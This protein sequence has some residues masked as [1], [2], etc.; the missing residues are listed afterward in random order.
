MITKV[1]TK[2]GILNGVTSNGGHALFKGIRYAKAPVGRLRFAPPEEPDSFDGEVICDTFGAASPQGLFDLYD[3]VGKLRQQM[4]GYPYPPRMDED[5]LFLN[6]YTPAETASDKLPVMFY[7]H[8]GG[9]QTWYGSCYEYCGDGLCDHGA[10]VVTINYRLNVFGFFAH[11]E[12]SRESGRNA[13]G[14]YGIMDMIAALKWV[15]EN[16]AGFGG[17]PDNIMIFGQSGG[18]RAVQALCCSPHTRG[19][20][21]HASMQSCGGIAPFGPYE[22]RG[23]TESLGRE[24]MEFCGCN[25]IAEM[26]ALP[27]QTL[28]QHNLEFVQSHRKTFNLD[29]DGYILPDFVENYARK[30]GFHKV[31]YIMGCTIDEGH[32]GE[33]KMPLFDR[34]CPSARALA[35]M[36]AKAGNAPFFYCFDRPQPGDDIGTPHSCDNR[37]IFRSLNESWRP[38]EQKDYD[39]SEIMMCYW[40]NFARTGNPNGK[41]LP[42]WKKF[43]GDFL[44]MHLTADG[45]YM[46]DFDKDGKL[47]ERE[48]SIVTEYYGK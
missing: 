21:K 16:I 48:A 9:L 7:I 22:G 33:G 31:D 41:D 11:P 40:S 24:F 17:D 13:S 18:G 15:R 27:W 28:E 10:V 6:V 37:Y 39:L 23:T 30:G 5:C 19:V 42:E 26:R 35:K 8:G 14:N 46:D 47:T 3:E 1:K 38:Y 43:D 29:K 20:F 32:L 45:C 44:E 12:L 34:M 36:L 2:Y 25:S 4:P